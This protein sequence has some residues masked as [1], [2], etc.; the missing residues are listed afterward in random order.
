MLFLHLFGKQSVVGSDTLVVNYSRKIEL[1]YK[2]QNTSLTLFEDVIISNYETESDDILVVDFPSYLLSFG[3]KNYFHLV[4]DELSQFELIKSK[5]SDIVPTVVSYRD[6]PV[7]LSSY[8]KFILKN[9]LDNNP[10]KVVNLSRYKEIKFSKLYCFYTFSSNQIYSKLEF[11]DIINELSRAYYRESMT[12]LRA[13]IFEKCVDSVANRNKKLYVTRK[14]ENEVIRLHYEALNA[15]KYKTHFDISLDSRKNAYKWASELDSKQLDAELLEVSRR[16]LRKD[17]EDYIES[18]FL[19]KGYISVSPGDLSVEDQISIF[20]SASHVAGI[21]GGG[22]INTVFCP[23]DAIIII[24]SPSNLIRG[25]GHIQINK[26]L[27]GESV[28]VIPR[29]A[30]KNYGMPIPGEKPRSYT[31]DEFR[32][33]LE[34][35]DL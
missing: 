13:S 30:D 4:K 10:K 29:D 35:L 12:A 16:Y 8:S 20:R 19:A 21:V 14:K 5:I 7:E 3:D 23:E 33:E 1:D 31:L 22:M 18:Y 25:G 6:M 32:K 27:F 17:I 11:T 15:V 34:M 9:Y 26:A 2:I 24:I 28:V